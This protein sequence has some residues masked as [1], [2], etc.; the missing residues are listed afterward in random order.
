MLDVGDLMQLD[1]DPNAD[2]LLDEGLPDLLSLT[3]G[4]GE[5]VEVACVSGVTRCTEQDGMLYAAVGEDNMSEVDADGVGG[6]TLNTAEVDELRDGS[7]EPVGLLPDAGDVEV[8]GD[9]AI[10]DST[11]A[12]L[13]GD[14]LTTDE[15]QDLVDEGGLLP[16]LESELDDT[17]CDL[18]G[19]LLCL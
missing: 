11:I 7:G 9:N 13:L 6:L 15:L 4:D 18:L 12:D 14:L 1:L 10:P 16:G 3:D 5:A 2:E 8:L 19:G 17:L